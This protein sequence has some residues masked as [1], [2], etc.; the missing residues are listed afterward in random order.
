MRVLFLLVAVVV[1]VLIARYFLRTSP[2]SAKKLLG[3]FAVAAAVIVLLLLLATGRLHWLFALVAAMLPFLYRLLPLLRYVPMLHNLYRR[4]QASRAARQGP[5][6]GQTSTVESRYFKMQLD[7]D[8][9][10][11]NGQVLIGSFKG[12]M[13]GSLTLEQ[14][15]SLLDECRDDADS[16]A[17]L[18]AYLDRMHA[19]WRD[20][21]QQ[22][23]AEDIGAGAAGAPRNGKMTKSE[24]YQVLGIEAG[25]SKQQVIDAHRRLMAKMHPD[26]GGSNY[27]AAKINLAKQVLLE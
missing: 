22:E 25:A 12:S 27:L 8:S 9:G 10:A 21:A 1:V 20:Q 13:L 6:T 7:H 26:R 24:A 4:Y 15:L 16:C 2:Q 19:Q 23:Q 18:T 11:M 17:L 14:L 5:A 3:Q